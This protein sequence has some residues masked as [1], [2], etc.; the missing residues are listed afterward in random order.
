MEAAL[1][2]LRVDATS[3]LEDAAVEVD[4]RVSLPCAA[5]KRDTVDLTVALAGVGVLASGRSRSCRGPGVGG[6]D[7]KATFFW[8]SVPVVPLVVLRELRPVESEEPSGRREDDSSEIG[9]GSAVTGRFSLVSTA[10][11]E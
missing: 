7:K 6:G 2:D 3:V 4:P 8:A 9:A 5:W 11:R 1:L 10:G